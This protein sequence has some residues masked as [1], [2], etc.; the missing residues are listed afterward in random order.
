MLTIPLRKE[1]ISTRLVGGYILLGI[2]ST[3]GERVFYRGV[4]AL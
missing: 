1:S 4:G 3:T 2:V